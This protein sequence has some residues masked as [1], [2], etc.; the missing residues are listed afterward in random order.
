LGQAV[1]GSA[2]ILWVWG[3]FQQLKLAQAFETLR[4]HG[5]ADV[6]N[7]KK[8]VMPVKTQCHG[9]DQKHRPPVINDGQNIAL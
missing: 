7:L 4:Q 5:A 8:L 6:Q 1:Q 3:F 2:R 9:R